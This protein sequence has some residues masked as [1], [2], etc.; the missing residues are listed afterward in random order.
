MLRMHDL[1]CMCS[2]FNLGI[3]FCAPKFFLKLL[4]ESL[5]VSARLKF[6]LPAESIRISDR[7]VTPLSPDD[8]CDG[9]RLTS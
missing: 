4:F 9:W 5:T 1:Y 6:F 8:A 7:L 2:R 3:F